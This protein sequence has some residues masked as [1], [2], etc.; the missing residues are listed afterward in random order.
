L[1]LPETGYI[2]YEEEQKV[3]VKRMDQLL[4]WHYPNLNLEKITR[5]RRENVGYLWNHIHDLETFSPIGFNRLSVRKTA[6]ENLKSRDTS[7]QQNFQ[8][9]DGYVPFSLPILT[10]PGSRDVIQQALLNRGIACYVGWTE[11][12]FGLDESAEAEQLKLRLLELP[13]H[14]YINRYQLETIADCLNEL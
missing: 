5:K 9:I 4:N 13:I 8:L 14:H 6:M 7:N 1:S 3:T 2:D 12:P 11:S 10:P